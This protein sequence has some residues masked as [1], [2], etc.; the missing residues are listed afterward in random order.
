M[1]GKQRIPLLKMVG[2]S[3][4]FPGVQALDRVNLELY[5][6]EVLALVGENGA[7]K[8]TLMNILGGCLHADAGNIFLDGDKISINTVH[9]AMELGIA[10]VHQE[11]NLS[12]NLD[13]GD[14]IFL[15]R[16]P[17]K[18][19]LLKLVDKDRVNEET[20]KV[21]K[22]I[23][24]TCSPTIIVNNLTI[25]LQQM[26]EIGKALSMN[27]RIIIMDEP[28][29]SLSQKEAEQLFRIIR[30]LR[31]QGISVIYISHRLGEVKELA[32]R[33][34]V[35]RDGKNSGN[36]AR[37]EISREAMVKLMVGRDTKNFYQHQYHCG[38][39]PIL[40]VKDL[41]VPSHPGHPISF[42]VCRG[43]IVVIA[44]LIGAGRTE[45]AHTIFGI[46]QPLG[47][48]ILLNGRS[49]S[50]RNSG[51]AI[52][53]G[54]CLAPENRALHGLVLEMALEDNVVLPGLYQY[55]SMALVD[56][57]R[58]TS[59][60]REMVRRMNIRTPSLIQ[61]TGCLSGGNQQKV[62]LS[63]WLSLKPEIL[64]LD[65][66][67]R[68][69]DVG[70]KQEI[71]YLLEELVA[72]GV[73][74]LII[75][76]E[77]QEVLGIADRILVMHEGRLT[78]ELLPADF[79]EEEIVNLATGGERSPRQREEPEEILVAGGGRTRS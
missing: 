46:D 13:I 6:G 5:P 69:I 49:I 68:G 56:R 21:L 36:L 19:G 12:G 26:V 38:E 23:G 77:M 70:A 48:E 47:G 63:K 15:G 29:S 7:G 9:Q 44:G 31:S 64:I 33:V 67:T 65:E 28:T 78:G 58:I 34:T 8:S 73:G 45:L 53:K 14:N 75:S 59:V 61:I 39:E 76:S 74:L 2:I 57:E 66:P 51:D 17:R 52:R 71:Y 25:G 35:L 18:S 24:M 79:S 32:D 42:K 72:H 4:L 27:T 41:I 11:L 37:E 10:F 50:I 22:R 1:D 43:E 3:K 60:T 62:V 54:I 20:S 30:E 16:E 55:Q 40:E